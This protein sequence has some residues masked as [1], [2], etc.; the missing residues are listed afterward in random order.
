MSEV[1]GQRGVC[2]YIGTRFRMPETKNLGVKSLTLQAKGMFSAAI[3]FIPQQR[4][5]HIRHMDS[6]PVS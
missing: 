2:L 6:D 1:F 4:M 3:D 5:A